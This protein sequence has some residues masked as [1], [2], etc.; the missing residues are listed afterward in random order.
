MHFDEWKAIYFDKKNS[1]KHIR[2][3]L[4]VGSDSFELTV[5]NESLH[6]A[7]PQAPTPW[8]TRTKHTLMCVLCFIISF[9]ES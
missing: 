2:G 7:P 4:L 5:I 1:Q 9:T 6:P 3:G 8:H